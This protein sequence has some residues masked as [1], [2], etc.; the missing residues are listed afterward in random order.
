MF[1]HVVMLNQPKN[2]MLF[3]SRFELE[4]WT[5]ILQRT[6]EHRLQEYIGAGAEV[7]FLIYNLV[8]IYN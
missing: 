4:Y 8:R 3:D 5:K 7:E 6:S 1:W 2:W